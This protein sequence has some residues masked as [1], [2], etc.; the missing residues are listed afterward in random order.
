MIHTLVEK[1]LKRRHF[2][3][4]ASFSEVSALYTAR[5][6][7][8]TAGYLV[9]MFVATYLY[10]IGYKLD[11]IAL[12]YVGY[13]CF[14]AISAYPAA[15][16]AAR[17]G[18]KHGMFMANILSIPALLAFSTVAE[19]GV[20]VLAVFTM[21]QATSITLYTQ[22][23][24]ISFSKVKNAQHAGKEIAFMNII[25]K[26]TAGLSPLAGGLSAWL[27]GPQIT[28]WIAAV[29]FCIAALPLLRTAEPVVTKQ[30]ISFKA[31][32]W[33]TTWR[34]FIASAGVGVDAASAALV[35]PL[36]LAAVLFADSNDSVYAKIGG[37]ASISL[38]VSFIA[39]RTYGLLID[40]RRGK[41]LLSHAVL[42][43]SLTHV[44]RALITTPLSAALVNII[45]ET[46]STGYMM[47]YTRGQYDLADRTGQRIAYLYLCEVC[48]N[49]GFAI[50]FVFMYGVSLFIF[51]KQTVFM[52]CFAAA[53]LL[54]L[55]ISSA[56]FPLYRK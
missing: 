17:F 46:T 42:G 32:P 37:L 29:L 10:Q 48:Y 5:L 1:L 40:R 41:D 13:F 3:R 30:K 51:D 23:H 2:W 44:M 11:Q 26:M 9:N 12:F 28:M 15:R 31:F 39:S 43:T 35:W 7:R 54:M 47:A 27:L 22:C 38:I 53:S 18:P 36:F 21:F 50:L 8:Q 34:T 56:R 33:R 55:S 24:N 25:D 6:L 16:Y 19:N 52:L 20:V 45:S 4:Y 14:K 49:L